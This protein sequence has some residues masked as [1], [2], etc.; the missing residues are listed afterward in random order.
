MAIVNHDALLA[1][2]KGMTLDQAEAHYIQTEMI[3]PLRGGVILGGYVG[4]YDGMD[5]FP[6]LRVMVQGKVY[7]VIVS[8]DDEQNGGGR[9]MIE[10]EPIRSLASNS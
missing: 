10:P 5:P 2:R 1:E 7:E 9:L 3:D 6:V 8:Q 4:E